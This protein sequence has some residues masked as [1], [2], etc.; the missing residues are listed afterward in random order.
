MTAIM[1]LMLGSFGLG[2]ALGD[3]GD[4]KDGLNAA[5]RVFDTIDSSRDDPLDGMSMK[6]LIPSGPC[7]GDIEF[8]NVTFSYPTRKNMT[9][10][11]NYN[12]SVSAGKTLAL[13]GPSGK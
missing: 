12:L 8:R 9:V 5:K 2:V 3:M 11:K 7:K 6:G 10:F 13:V 4:Q 1:S